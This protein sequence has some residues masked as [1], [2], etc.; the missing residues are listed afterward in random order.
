MKS[1]LAE[2]DRRMRHRAQR[3]AIEAGERGE[4]V[5]DEDVAAFL[6]SA[7]GGDY[8]SFAGQDDPGWYDIEGSDE[9][10]EDDNVVRPR[11]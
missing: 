7:P 4:P 11:K 5:R 6:L 1:L 3:L 8:D 10:S 9:E 2:D